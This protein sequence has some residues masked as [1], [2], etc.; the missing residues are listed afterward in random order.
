MI[1]RDHIAGQPGYSASTGEPC[2]LSHGLSGGPALWPWP[3]LNAPTR[4]D[5]WSGAN[6]PLTGPSQLHSSETLGPELEA[7]SLGC[8][9]SSC[10]SSTEE[11]H[12]RFVQGHIAQMGWGQDW[13]PDKFSILP[14][15][16]GSPQEQQEPR[17]A[18]KDLALTLGCQDTE[19]KSLC[20]FP[21]PVS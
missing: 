11:T 18:Y 6:N 13:S 8:L 15:S 12:S 4:H 1:C 7:S 10:D 16:H 17:L 14:L 2:S 9:T 20:T 3:H 5:S 19:R 21:K